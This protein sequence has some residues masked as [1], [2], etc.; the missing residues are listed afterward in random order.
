MHDGFQWPFYHTLDIWVQMAGVTSLL[1][2]FGLGLKYHMG[3]Q[4]AR[5]LTPW[6]EELMD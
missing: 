3:Q 5:T 4:F 6:R 1:S 2:A